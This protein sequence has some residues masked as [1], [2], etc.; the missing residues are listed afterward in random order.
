MISSP[1]E[2]TACSFNDL[3]G[4]IKEL[5][6]YNLS[7]DNHQLVNGQNVFG[8]PLHGLVAGTGCRAKPFGYPIKVKF[9]GAD[10]YVVDLRPMTAASSM[11]DH[12]VT[13]HPDY[14][15]LIL[16]G[17]LTAIWDSPDRSMV[18][19]IAA[20][21]SPI[22]A[23]WL[24]STLS[25]AFNLQVDQRTE[26][27]IIAAYFYWQQLGVEANPDK[28]AA[29]IAMDLKLDFDRVIEVIDTAGDMSDLNGLIAALKASSGGIRMDKIDVS[30]VWQ[31]SAGVWTG[32]LGRN[33]MEVALEFPPYIVALTTAALTEKGYRRSRF[34]DYVSLF[35]R[36]HEVRQLPESIK[37]LTKR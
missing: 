31:V 35:D 29:R 24:S 1:Q 27:S 18:A 17:I 28:I 34:F 37:Y 14:E 30:T 25:A 13:N 23:T 21:L 16:I 6:Q 32:A 33:I 11:R 26:V 8:L 7:N 4:I 12:K 36:R 3:S 5:E 10:A 19:N 20:D 22:Y 15:L 9:R 2:T